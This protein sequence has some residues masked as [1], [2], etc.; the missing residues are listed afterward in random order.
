VVLLIKEL[1]FSY[2]D[3]K[4]LRVSVICSYLKRA[5]EIAEQKRLEQI[6]L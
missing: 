2:K 1:N 5:L 6:E 3:I 4:E